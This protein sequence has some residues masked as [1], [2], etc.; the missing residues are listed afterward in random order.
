MLYS[1]EDDRVSRPLVSSSKQHAF[2]PAVAGVKGQQAALL[3]HR[4]HVLEPPP[5]LTHPSKGICVNTAALLTLKAVASLNP[6]PIPNTPT[7]PLKY[8]RFSWLEYTCTLPNKRKAINVASA[9]K[10]TGSPLKLRCDKSHSDLASTRTNT[11]LPGESRQ[12]TTLPGLCDS[13]LRALQTGIFKDVDVWWHSL[14]ESR[15]LLERGCWKHFLMV[16]HSLWSLSLCDQA[17][18]GNNFE[19]KLG[20]MRNVLYWVH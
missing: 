20:V 6:I 11:L 14:L 7:S 3:P 12:A 10:V 1:N 17:A 13:K 15:K 19:Q 2:E 5:P 18:Y 9:P 16:L 8:W 4:L